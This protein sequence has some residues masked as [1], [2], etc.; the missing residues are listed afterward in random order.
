VNIISVPREVDVME[1]IYT[2]ME[3]L[4]IVFIYIFIFGGS[5]NDVISN[6]G[7]MLSHNEMI[8]ELK[9]Y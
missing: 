8:T 3:V 9:G 6:S 7:C 2:Q 5:F 1:S 4:F